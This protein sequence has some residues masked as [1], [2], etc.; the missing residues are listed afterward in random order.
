[1]FK[2]VATASPAGITVSTPPSTII[3]VNMNMQIYFIL[4]AEL[5]VNIL[6]KRSV[7]SL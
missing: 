1:M 6:N 2:A 4:I 5:D 7:V 3:P